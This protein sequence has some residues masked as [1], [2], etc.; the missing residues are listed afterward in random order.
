MRRQSVAWI[1]VEFFGVILRLHWNWNSFGEKTA[2]LIFPFFRLKY[3]LSTFLDSFD[4][5]DFPISRSRNCKVNREQSFRLFTAWLDITTSFFLVLWSRCAPVIFGTWT[6]KHTDAST[7]AT[8]IE[9]LKLIKGW[10]DECIVCCWS[11][12]EQKTKMWM[13]ITKFGFSVRVSCVT[14]NRD[15]R[16][17]LRLKRK[18]RTK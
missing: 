14:T 1:C 10:H 9:I 13:K 15:R 3:P 7:T 11:C 5:H 6:D 18:L 12:W 17:K 4:G 8:K 2:L 16:K